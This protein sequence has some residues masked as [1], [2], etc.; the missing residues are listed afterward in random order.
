MNNLRTL[1]AGS[2]DVSVVIRIVDSTDGTPETGVVYN[3]S[4]I[5]LEYRRDGATSTAITEATLATLDAA[6]SDGGFLHIGNGYYRLDLPDAACAIG[7]GQVLVH[8]TVT[9]MVV[10]GGTITLTGGAIAGLVGPSPIDGIIEAGVA[11]SAT[12]TTLVGRAAA[13]DGIIKAGHVLHVYGTTQ[14]YWQSV[15]V[16]SVSTD[17]FTIAAWPVATPS[18]TIYYNVFGQ[19]T[20]SSTVPVPANMVQLGNDTQ[21]ATDLKDFA[22]AG[23]DP[24]TNK[25]QGLVLA[26]AVTT[27][28]GLAAN[29]I[30]AAATAADFTTEIQS[31]L[32]TAAALDTVDNF[33]DTEVAAILAAVDTEVAAIKAKTDSLTFTTAGIVDANIQQINDVTITGNGGTGTE[34]SV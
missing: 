24:A 7:V 4:G 3:T 15:M 1:V 22:D 12:A 6:H 31:G 11:Q 5:A 25:V 9:G 14:G 8:G 16:D 2:T 34:F 28:N 32:A 29:V 18:G 27:V 33:L 21:S 26:D 13:T 30:T 19:P 20:V 23:Y 17:T 10:I